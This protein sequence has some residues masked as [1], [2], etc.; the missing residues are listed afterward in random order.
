MNFLGTIS[1][2]IVPLFIAISIICCIYRKQSP[3][4]AFIDG[5]KDGIN[6]SLTVLPY[7]I[8]IFFSI[9]L[10]TSSGL[11]DIVGDLFNKFFCK[12]GIPNGLGLFIILR[13]LSGTGSMSELNNIFNSFGV[14]SPQG[15]FASALMSSTETIFY[16]IPM[17]LSPSGIKN[18]P[19][20]LW[21]S[22]I[23]MITGL[24]V[25]AFLFNTIHPSI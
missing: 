7:L 8:A 13:P 21:I 4:S 10:F 25:A 17:Y 23:S 24:W 16:T 19:K 14:D 5:A 12:I 2:Y 1:I 15:I 3:Y 6:N 11:A 18:S 20:A 9:K 22:L